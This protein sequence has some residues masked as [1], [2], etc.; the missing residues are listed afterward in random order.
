[1]I[2]NEL[3]LFPLSLP[4]FEPSTGRAIV[5]VRLSQNAPTTGAE[6]ECKRGGMPDGGDAYFQFEIGGHSSCVK[7]TKNKNESPRDSRLKNASKFG[8]TG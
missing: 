1:M 4:N 7:Y 2:I 5:G 3:T 8:V 6:L